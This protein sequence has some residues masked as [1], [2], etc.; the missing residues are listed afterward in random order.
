MLLLTR[1]EMSSLLMSDGTSRH[2]ILIY[3][4]YI[5]KKIIKPPSC[6]RPGIENSLMRTSKLDELRAWNLSDL[7]VVNDVSNLGLRAAG[8]NGRGHA[9]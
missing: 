1:S 4:T 6:V 5:F 9:I 7:V 8:F 3:V 2:F